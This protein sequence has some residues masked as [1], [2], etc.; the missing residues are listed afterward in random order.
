MW[1]LNMKKTPFL[2]LLLII[3]VSC[4]KQEPSGTHIQRNRDMHHPVVDFAKWRRLFPIETFEKKD[5]PRQFSSTKKG[6]PLDLWKARGTIVTSPSDLCQI[7]LVR[8]RVRTKHDLGRAVPVDTFI[9]RHGAPDKPYLT[10]IGGVP[11]REKTLPWPTDQKGNPYTFVAQFCF[12]DSKDIVSSQLP[13]DIMLIFFRDS[14]S[15]FGEPQDVHIEW[16]SQSLHEPM[17]KADCPTP[18]FP[19]PEL[20]GEIHRCNEYPDSWDV[21]EQ[22]GHYQMYLFVTSQSTKIGRETFVIQNDPRE[23]GQEFFCA[24]NSIQPSRKWP[25]T[26]MED[27]PD[28]PME[29]DDNYGWGAYQMMFGDVGCMYFMIDAKGNITWA[30]DCY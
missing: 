6:A 8:E 14:E 13:A 16:S 17:T 26:N 10:K 22:Q 2:L 9:W 18:R 3:V 5:G 1:C 15:Y 11:H 4:T 12:L 24:L 21:F 25:F 27:L 7:E 30:S 23:N 29:S 20:T 28:D 19:V